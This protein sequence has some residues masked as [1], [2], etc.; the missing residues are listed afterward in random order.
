MASFS[1]LLRQ[2][3]PERIKYQSTIG[4]LHGEGLTCIKKLVVLHTKIMNIHNN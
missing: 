4:A 3:V 2:Q 1:Q